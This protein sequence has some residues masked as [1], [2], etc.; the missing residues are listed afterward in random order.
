[1]GLKVGLLDEDDRRRYA[2]GRAFIGMRRSDREIA[3]IGVI[4]QILDNCKTCHLAMVDDGCPYVIPLSFAYIMADGMLA[5]FFHSAKEGRKI[6]VLRKN[7]T[8]CFEMCIEGEPVFAAETPCNSGYYY[9]CVHGFGKAHFIDDVDEKCSA[10]SLLMKH[11][12]GIDVAITPQQAESV[13]VFKVVSSNFT[14]K[15]K[16]RP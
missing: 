13:C 5:L 15:V 4:K 16:Q 2:G 6:D 8:V 9:S 11:Q 14:C 7:S 1:M 10:L 3:N 12:A